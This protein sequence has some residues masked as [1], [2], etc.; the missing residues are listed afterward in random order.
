MKPF[1]GFPPKMQFTSIP[2]IFFSQLLP[3][4]SDIAELKTTLHI[5]MVLYRQ[6]GYPRFTSFAELSSDSALMSSLKQLAQPAEEALRRALK[7][8]V[9]RG[10]IL[11]LPLEKEGKPQD[12][13]LLNAE[14]E[15]KV[16]EKIKQGEL[17]LPG[18]KPARDSG[19][20]AEEL[21]DIFTI[22]EDNIGMLTPMIAEELKEAERLYPT[23]WIR[24]AIKEAVLHNK[25]KWPYIA[26]ILEN[27]SSE[28]NDY[29]AH[30]RDAKK[31][32]RD[33]YVKG[34]Y[35]HMVKR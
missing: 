6:R 1:N 32:G 17:E 8:A 35:G 11:H 30:Q 15:R 12:I 5:L 28:G 4:I 9:K 34:K 14:S 22:Y 33:K 24:D 27:W 19:I 23:P 21:P 16:I 18:L 13:Y 10:S 2:N 31:E 29:G 7:M 25:R 26:R 20:E 3:Q